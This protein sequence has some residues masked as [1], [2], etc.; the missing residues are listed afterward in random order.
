MQKAV[1]L[2][3]GENEEILEMAGSEIALRITNSFKE[4]VELHIERGGEQYRIQSGASVK[5]EVNGPDNDILELE[6][7]EGRLVV[8]GWPGSVLTISAIRE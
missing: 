7:A 1:E 6:Y 5:V 4:D 8:Y 2:L 3:G